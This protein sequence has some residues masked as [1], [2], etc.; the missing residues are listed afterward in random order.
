LSRPVAIWKKPFWLWG[1]ILFLLG[2]WNS[3]AAAQGND[4]QSLFGQVN[5]LRAGVG[6]HAYVWN[7]QLAAA[8]QQQSEYMAVTGD[9][10]HT[11]SNGSTPTSRATANGYTGSMI[12][13]NIYGGLTAQASDAWNFWVNSGVHYAT[14]TNARDNEIGIG[15]AT[16]E[17]GTFFAL[18]IGYRSDVNAPPAPPPAENPPSVVESDSGN[19][20]GQAIPQAPPATLPPPTLTFTPFPTLTPSVTWTPTFTWTPSPTNTPLLPTST[21]ISLPTAQVIALALTPTA[22]A[23]AVPVT[24]S[25]PP[26][27]PAI[28]ERTQAPNGKFD[29]RDLLPVLLIGQG[30]LLSMG[31]YSLFFRN[32]R[33]RK[34]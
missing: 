31:L 10:S 12:A 13:E 22:V 20:S 5:S 24:Q 17:H 30:V 19:A 26:I 34:L 15:M 25:D 8:A 1:C 3:P 27:V 16:G 28:K 14:L 9:V 6:L 2:W 29:L 23:L 32:S 11:Q 7:N 18:V 4:P 33:K 21:S